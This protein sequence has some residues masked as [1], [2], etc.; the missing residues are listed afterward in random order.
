MK[1]YYCSFEGAS[2]VGGNGWVIY[3]TD[4]FP[5]YT[6]I[7]NTLEEAINSVR[8]IRDSGIYKFVEAPIFRIE[9]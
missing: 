6:K 5:P 9:K 3:H 4:C 8:E 7:W 1:K 2:K